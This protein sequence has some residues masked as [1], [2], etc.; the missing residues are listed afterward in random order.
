MIKKY[1]QENK[2]SEIL[3]IIFFTLMLTATFLKGI[4]IKS[5]MSISIPMPLYKILCAHILIITATIGIILSI[6]LIKDVINEKYE[7]CKCIIVTIN[8][9]ILIYISFQAENI[10][11]SKRYVNYSFEIGYYLSLILN[12]LLLF[13]QIIRNK[14]ICDKKYNYKEIPK[15]D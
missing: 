2:I 11:L 14:T 6:L 1:L 9:I 8:I 13:K 12:I 4:T 10:V 5:V 3:D 7:K 15:I